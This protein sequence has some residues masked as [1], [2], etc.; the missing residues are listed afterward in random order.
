MLYMAHAICVSFSSLMR[1]LTLIPHFFEGVKGASLK[2]VHLFG[3]PASQASVTETN[4]SRD[5]LEF[6]PRTTKC[7]GVHIAEALLAVLLVAISAAT[8]KPS[9]SAPD[10]SSRSEPCAPPTSPSSSRPH[11]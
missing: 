8:P 1:I 11:S 4:S 7:I 9:A 2:S 3:K 10:P 5:L 6:Q